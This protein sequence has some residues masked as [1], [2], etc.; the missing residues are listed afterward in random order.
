MKIAE[1]FGLIF[2]GLAVLLAVVV[3]RMAAVQAW[4]AWLASITFVTFLAFGY[5]KAVAGKGVMRVP[6]DV[7]LLLVLAGGTV[8]A[9]VAMPFFHHKTRKA[10]F[11]MRFWGVVAVQALLIGS[12]VMWF[13]R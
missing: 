10:A 5:D 3:F 12:Y 13:R 8:G 2:F 6:E 7:L 9:L 4:I 11:R 1:K